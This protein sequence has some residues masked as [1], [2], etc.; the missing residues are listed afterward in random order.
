MKIARFAERTQ[1]SPYTLR[2]YET[3]GL[4]S[5][6]RDTSG[7]RQFNEKDIEWVKFITRLK[8]TGMP[9]A[10]IC[11]YAALREKGA[12]TLSQRRQMLAEHQAV[13]QAHIAQAQAHLQALDNKI[14]FYDEALREQVA[15]QNAQV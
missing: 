13:L 8:E 9:L 5:I 11:A 1:L 14:A 3:L 12:V 2:Y 4:L 10:Q 7:H 6:A 15:H